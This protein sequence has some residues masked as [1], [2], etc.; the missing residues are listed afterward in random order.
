MTVFTSLLLVVKETETELPHMCVQAR[1][2]EFHI[3]TTSL[4][5]LYALLRRSF[6]LT[7]LNSIPCK[8]CSFFPY[9]L[10]VFSAN[11]IPRNG[12]TTLRSSN[13]KLEVSLD[14]IHQPHSTIFLR[15][16]FPTSLPLPPFFSLAILS[17]LF[18][19]NSSH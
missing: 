2:C 7:H 8:L 17:I 18:F 13:W 6:C 9:I 3:S 14:S 19:A 11:C 5:S 10:I 15:K 1:Y 4:T 16:Q 12:F